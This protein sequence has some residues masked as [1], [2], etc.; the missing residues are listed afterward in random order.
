MWEVDPLDE[1][2]E[3][4][5]H[6]WFPGRQTHDQK[7]WKPLSFV[8]V[9]RIWHRR[10][11]A[12]PPFNLFRD[13][14]NKKNGQRGARKGW[15]K[16]PGLLF[17]QPRLSVL[18]TLALIIMRPLFGLSVAFLWAS[19]GA[20]DNAVCTGHPHAFLMLS[21]LARALVSLIFPLV[22]LLFVFCTRQVS[23]SPIVNQNKT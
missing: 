4:S 22:L 21:D 8:S 6:I 15:R 13:P 18:Y 14:K 19:S 16:W 9:K 23:V 5:S 20:S 10:P 12:R 3:L 7:L 17:P 1:W 2:V 11:P